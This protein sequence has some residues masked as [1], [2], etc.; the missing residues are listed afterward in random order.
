MES[1]STRSTAVP[2]Q[3]RRGG[4]VVPHQPTFLQRAVAMLVFLTLR[5]VACTLRHRLE[6]HSG[7]FRGGQVPQAIYVI[8]HNRLAL[9]LEGYRRHTRKQAVTPGLAAMVSASKDGGFLAA[10]LERHGVQP[11]RGSSSRRGAQALLELTSWAQ[12]GY[13]LAITPDGPRGP[14]YV[15][16]DGVLSLAQVTGLPLIPVSYSLSWRWRLKSWDGFLV[17]LPFACWELVVAQPMSVPR[18]LSDPGR[19]ELRQQLETTLRAITRD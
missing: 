3:P 13:D 17:P 1:D 2:R 6:D 10:I 8:W 19:E 12:R 4:V 9:C 14:R 16:Q 7:L 11:V 18:D 15:V 5:A